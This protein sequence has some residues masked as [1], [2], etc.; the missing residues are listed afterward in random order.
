MTEGMVV[1]R[2]ELAKMAA[3]TV[4]GFLRTNGIPALVSADDVGGAIPAFDEVRGVRV[5]VAAG[6]LERARE[7]LESQENEAASEEAEPTTD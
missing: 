3:D 1:V 2:E 6:D 4:A 5:L 7:L